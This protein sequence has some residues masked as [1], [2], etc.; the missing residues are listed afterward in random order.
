M[1]RT[2]AAITRSRWIARAGLV[3]ALGLVL[4]SGLAA[5]ASVLAGG[6]IGHTAV[7]AQD[8]AGTLGNGWGG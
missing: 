7:A 4:A 3:A 5:P 8:A 1:T 6:T 2:D